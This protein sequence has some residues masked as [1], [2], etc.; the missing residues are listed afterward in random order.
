MISEEFLSRATQKEALRRTRS[1]AKKKGRPDDDQ[2][3]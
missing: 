2:L 3:F 1:S